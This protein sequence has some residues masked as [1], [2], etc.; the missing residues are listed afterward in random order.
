M[1]LGPV[2]ADMSSAGACAHTLDRTLSGRGHWCNFC[3][4][5]AVCIG[6]TGSE[7]NIRAFRAEILAVA[8]RMARTASGVRSPLRWS[9]SATM[10]LTSAAE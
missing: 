8:R 1:S 10:P 9:I 5:C 3:R 6:E 2:S 7:H 4:E